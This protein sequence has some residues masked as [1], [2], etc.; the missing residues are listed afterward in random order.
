MLS[1]SEDSFA[2]ADLIP[3]SVLL[4][5]I[6]SLITLGFLR[7]RVLNRINHNLAGWEL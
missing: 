1:L 5:L 3:L 7:Q 6:L 4:F 2:A